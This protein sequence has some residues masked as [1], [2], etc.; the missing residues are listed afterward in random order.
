LA[1]AIVDDNDLEAL[2]RQ[3]EIDKKI[4]SFDSAQDDISVEQCLNTSFTQEE[5]EEGKR[6]AI[7]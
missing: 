3:N 6:E 2:K 5:L 4:I 1:T 7:K